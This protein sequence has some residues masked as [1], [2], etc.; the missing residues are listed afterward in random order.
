M[1]TGIA[2][3]VMLACVGAL[4]IDAL[5]SIVCRYLLH[6][7]SAGEYGPGQLL[8]SFLMILIWVLAERVVR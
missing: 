2:E 6:D 5:H 4:I 7:E 1:T 3:L 8:M